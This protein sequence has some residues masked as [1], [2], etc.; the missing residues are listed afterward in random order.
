IATYKYV[1][2]GTN[3]SGFLGAVPVFSYPYQQTV[4]N[5]STVT[6]NYTVISSDPINDLNF[7]QGSPVGYS[8]VEA[9]KGDSAHNMGKT[10]YEFTNLTDANSYLNTPAFPYA[11]FPQRDWAMGLPKRVS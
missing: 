3:S 2:S 5:G 8:R 4:I 7:T 1:T 10:V 11:P 9:I 6:T